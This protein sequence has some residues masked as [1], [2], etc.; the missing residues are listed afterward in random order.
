MTCDDVQLAIEMTGRVVAAAL[1]RGEI[2][3]HLATCRSCAAYDD[4][5]KETE[6]AM[7]TTTWWNHDPIDPA[8]VRLRVAAVAAR[9]HERWWPSLIGIG[10][11]LVLELLAGFRVD[12][13]ALAAMLGATG[14]TVWRRARR[15]Q[16]LQTAL[17]G[18]DVE[19]VQG[20]RSHLEHQIRQ[21]RVG[22]ACL[23]CVWVPATG[24][25]FAATPWSTSA[26]I[27]LPGYAM[28]LVI[29]VLVRQRVRALR[30]EQALLG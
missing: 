5:T 13:P 18:S 10:V 4:L 15:R 25:L 6:T 2:D 26:M 1:S 11:I 12:M 21:L 23:L 19:L 28:L 3:A 20:L 17:V 16:A 22:L 7:S 27:A 29:A 9:L 8:A 30:R 24:T 14:W